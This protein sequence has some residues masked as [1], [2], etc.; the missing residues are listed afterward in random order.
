MKIKNDKTK[1]G[2]KF[3]FISLFSIFLIPSIS[4]WS[5]SSDNYT[6]SGAIVS[7]GEL[8]ASSTNYESD[9]FI[10][11]STSGNSNS[12]LF[13][14]ILGFFFPEGDGDSVVGGGNTAPGDVTLT[15]PTNG[16]DTSVNR[17]QVLVWQEAIDTDSD[18]LT[19]DLNLTRLTFTGELDC[20]F[21]GSV[22]TGISETNYTT[23]E[24]CVD[25]WYFWK[26]RAYDGTDYGNWS[27]FWN[28]SVSSY[29]AVSMLNSEIDF[30]V[31]SNGDSVNTSNGTISGLILENTGNVKINF[32]IY[33]NNSLWSNASLNTSYF[34]YKSNYSTE[35]SAFENSSS[36][37]TWANVSSIE[38]N[39]LNLLDYNNSKDIALVDILIEVPENET[40]GVKTSSL[41]LT[42][43][44][45]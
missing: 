43:S 41:V 11:S 20:S 14:T 32:S 39:L 3:V 4:A 26:V 37:M 10:G 45:A 36:Q 33:A 44:V 28:F 9:V 12:S 16:S 7:G 40:G 30:G 8:G 31:L 21:N 23:P 34:Q 42:S 29:V 19:Y 35:E 1:V 5:S 25:D 2:I 13:S 22:Y 15:S 24:L 38:T 6:S 18:P 27:D 17:T